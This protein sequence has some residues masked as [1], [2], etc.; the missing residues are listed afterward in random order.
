M[1]RANER[2]PNS[3]QPATR[4]DKHGRVIG[5]SVPFKPSTSWMKTVSNPRTEGGATWLGLRWFDSTTLSLSM[6]RSA[7]NGEIRRSGDEGEHSPIA[8][9]D[10]IRRPVADSRHM[11]PTSN[12]RRCHVAGTNLETSR[13]SRR[14]GSFNSM[15]EPHDAIETFRADLRTIASALNAIR[16]ARKISLRKLATKCGVN[17]QNLSAIF[18]HKRPISLNEIDRIARALDLSIRVEVTLVPIGNS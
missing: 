9:V 8:A 3:A 1:T 18:N 13:D 14:D 12:G 7:E 4:R 11:R 10:V 2:V 16:E 5:F 17:A 6:V 15:S